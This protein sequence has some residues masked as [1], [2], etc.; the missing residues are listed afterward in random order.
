MKGVGGRQ[1]GGVRRGWVS[2]QLK[3]RG[4]RWCS[5][6]CWSCYSDCYLHFCSSSF[7]SVRFF[8]SLSTFHFGSI[9]IRCYDKFFVLTFWLFVSSGRSLEQEKT[10]LR[11]LESSLP[12]AEEPGSNRRDWNKCWIFIGIFP[13]QIWR[14]LCAIPSQLIL[15]WQQRSWNWLINIFLLYGSCKDFRGHFFTNH[16]VPRRSCLNNRDWEERFAFKSKLM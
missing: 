11:R 15:E 9:I 2:L 7:L 5:H 16:T 8:F 1:E 14:V 13:S 12:L 6:S 4:C 3:G 10:T